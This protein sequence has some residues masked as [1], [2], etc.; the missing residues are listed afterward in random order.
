MPSTYTPIATTTLATVEQTVTFNS[1]AGY[2]DLMIV[3]AVKNTG[4]SPY[5]VSWGGIRFN[6]DTTGTNYSTT[7]MGGFNGPIP[8]AGSSRSVGNAQA[9]I[10]AFRSDNNYFG[11]FTVHIPNYATTTTYKQAIGISAGTINFAFQGVGLW[12]N[13]A[14]ITSLTF[15]AE[16]VSAKFAIGTTFTLYGILAA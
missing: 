2:T 10:N 1:F 15:V 8:G 16:D 9:S 14:A 11:T 3:G 6:G 13:T 5:V 12:K 7:D 4:G